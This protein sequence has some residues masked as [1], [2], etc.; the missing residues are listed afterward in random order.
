MKGIVEH[1]VDAP[2]AFPDARMQVG[3][4]RH[5]RLQVA[6]GRCSARIRR[7]RE[8]HDPKQKVAYLKKVADIWMGQGKGEQANKVVDEILKGNGEGS[9]RR[10]A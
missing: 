3:D 2:K 7:R 5:G 1:M 6:L 4:A 10:R 8:R 9:L